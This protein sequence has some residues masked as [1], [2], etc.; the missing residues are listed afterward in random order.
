MGVKACKSDTVVAGGDVAVSNA[1]IATR[2]A[3]NTI[4]VGNHHVVVDGDSRNPHS[5]ALAEVNGPMRSFADGNA[6]QQD[7]LTAMK[8]ERLPG[9]LVHLHRAFDD[10]LLITQVAVG[11]EVPF[12]LSNEYISPRVEDT[13]SF[14]CDVRS[15]GMQ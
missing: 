2:C 10:V 14:H 13:T 11:F 6:A 12:A 15:T 5:F 8:D 7:I 9:A 3:M 1:Y 4:V